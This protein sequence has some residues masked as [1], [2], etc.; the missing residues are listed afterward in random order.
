MY[1]FFNMSMSLQKLMYQPINSLIP[2]PIA[3]VYEGGTAWVAGYE[4]LQPPIAKISMST[5]RGFTE[6]T[7]IVSTL[8]LLHHYKYSNTV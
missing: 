1:L 5:A 4:V 6:C 2:D 8:N 3:P 7:T